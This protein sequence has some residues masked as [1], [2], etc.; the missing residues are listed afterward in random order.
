MTAKAF[1]RISREFKEQIVPLKKAIALCRDLAENWG[2]SEDGEIFSFEV[3]QYRDREDRQKAALIGAYGRPE[4]IQT[5]E[6]LPRILLSHFCGTGET[7]DCFA[8]AGLAGLRSGSR[9]EAAFDGLRENSSTSHRTYTAAMADQAII[10]FVSDFMGDHPVY[11]QVLRQGV[12]S[13]PV[14]KFAPQ[15]LA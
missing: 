2:P 12:A 9:Y 1:N 6:P 13:V 3:V 10:R 11:R 5:G 7:A 4:L 14:K 8:K 15:P